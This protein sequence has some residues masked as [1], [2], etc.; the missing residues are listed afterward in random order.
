MSGLHTIIST[1]CLPLASAPVPGQVNVGG[2]GGLLAPGT[3]LG[4][5]GLGH[6]GLGHLRL[7]RLDKTVSMKYLTNKLLSARTVIRCVASI[8]FLN[9]HILVNLEKESNGLTVGESNVQLDFLTP[10][11]N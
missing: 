10:G 8:A 1:L 5:L 7:G 4:H 11:T 9:R 3:G 6:L 2:E